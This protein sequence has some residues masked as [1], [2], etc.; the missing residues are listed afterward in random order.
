LLYAAAARRFFFHATDEQR[1]QHAQEWPQDTIP[2]KE[3]PP[4]HRDWCLPK[5]PF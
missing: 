4:Y 2:P 3:L 1:T 5:G